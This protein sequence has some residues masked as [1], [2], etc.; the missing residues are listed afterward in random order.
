MGATF[1]LIAGRHAGKR[2]RIAP[3]HQAT[4]EQLDKAA[5]SGQHWARLAVSGLNALNTGR[6]DK[7]NIF[8]RNGKP[9]G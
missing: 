8:K 3:S 7:D 4:Y 5:K 1:P 9:W 6:L 2:I